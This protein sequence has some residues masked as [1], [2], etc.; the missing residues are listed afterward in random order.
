M[1]CITGTKKTRPMKYFLI[2]LISCLIGC[3]V[4]SGPVWYAESKRKQ[5]VLKSQYAQSDTL[6]LKY[7]VMDTWYIKDAFGRQ[8]GAAINYSSDTVW[9]NITN[10]LEKTGLPFQVADKAHQLKISDLYYTKIDTSNFKKRILE[11]LLEEDVSKM[12]IVPVVGYS[13]AWNQEINAGLTAGSISQ[14]DRIE[15]LDVHDLDLFILK[16]DVLYYYSKVRRR[17]SLTRDPSEPY[18]Y[19]FP[20]ELWDTLMYMSTRDYVERM[21]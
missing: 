16:G 3:S 10:S 6:Y 4:T 18:R 2:I 8:S 12:I 7:F 13:S 20:Q 19:D 21:R 1:P 17:E 15:H 14:S 11:A 5:K 9:K